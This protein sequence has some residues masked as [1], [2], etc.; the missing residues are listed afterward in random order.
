MN[1]TDK[2]CP[3]KFA[4]DI[5]ICGDSC[6]GEACAWWNINPEGCAITALVSWVSNMAPDRRGRDE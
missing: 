3:M 2:L 1:K 6:N 5:T 4:G